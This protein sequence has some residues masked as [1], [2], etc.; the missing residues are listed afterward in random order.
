MIWLPLLALV[1]GAPAQDALADLPDPQ[2]PVSAEFVVRPLR[3]VLDRLGQQMHVKLT[4]EKAIENE[5]IVLVCQSKP[6]LEVLRRLA[7]HFD[8][9]WQKDGGEYRLV[10]P[11]EQ[12]Q[13]ERRL[14]GQLLAEPVER[15]QKHVKQLLEESEQYSV[16]DAI[17]KSDELLG[18]LV[19]AQVNGVDS[20][21]S[22][23]A[24]ANYR[25]VELRYNL[26]SR[27]A[28]RCLL[29]LGRDRAAAFG[30][31]GRVVFSSLPTPRQIPLPSEA[32]QDVRQLLEMLYIGA[33]GK[34]GRQ[35]DLRGYVP[36]QLWLVEDSIYD[37]ERIL[38]SHP[39]NL[40]VRVALSL[41]TRPRVTATGTVDIVSQDGILLARHHIGVE[42]PFEIKPVREVPAVFNVP[43]GDS[44]FLTYIAK[45]VVEEGFEA[46]KFWQ[47]GNPADPLE[48]HGRMLAEISRLTGVPVIADAYDGLGQ[49]MPSALG[50]KTCGEILQ[51]ATSRSWLPVWKWVYDGE[52]LSLRFEEWPLARSS[53]VDRESLFRLR[54]RFFEKGQLDLND[55]A[56]VFAGSEQTFGFYRSTTGRRSVNAFL[57]LWASVPPNLRMN[58]LQTGRLRYGDLPPSARERFNAL[59]YEGNA[60]FLARKQDIYEDEHLS[61]L[62]RI[63][64][65]FPELE[66]P[67]A[68]QPD[69]PDDEVTQFRPTSAL[70]EDSLYFLV[71]EFPGV[72]VFSQTGR[73]I[74]YDISMLSAISDHLV[75][76]Y[77][78]TARY[79]PATIREY[80]IVLRAG[81]M[82]K[83]VKIETCRFDPN[84]KPGTWMDLPKSLRDKIEEARRRREGRG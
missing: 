5:L 59:L 52:W 53:N 8:W 77:G 68:Y 47:K 48:D 10:L 58:A 76:F 28:V 72:L 23:R 66:S 55:L 41:N 22:N 6:R 35:V 84:A 36:R 3:E 75:Q 73:L 46:G 60:S 34:A 15:L 80:A 39:N 64:Q 13:A 83:Y 81:P 31:T 7:S 9:K 37:A 65:Q 42:A 51:R 27:I 26:F 57:A 20:A 56:P 18:E 70:P 1:A 29:S 62:D 12:L 25:R 16:A 38:A 78:L 61:F 49:G 40:I 24:E 63:Y 14:A 74:W 79:V 4:A 82:T 50:A 69:L 17:A 33:Q 44:P 11:P 2:A 71:G 45:D 30:E 19:N 21:T 43:F 54:D 32:M 67:R